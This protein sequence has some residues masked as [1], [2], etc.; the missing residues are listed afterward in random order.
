MKTPYSNG[1][2]SVVVGLLVI[3]VFTAGSLLITPHQ[4]RPFPEQKTVILKEIEDLRQEVAATRDAK[5]LA[6]L[7]DKFR[8]LSTKTLLSLELAE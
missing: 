3:T 1:L 6:H 8:D 7:Y 2:F 4:R 5:E